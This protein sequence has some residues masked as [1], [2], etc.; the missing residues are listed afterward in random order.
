MHF[1]R[2]F[3][4]LGLLILFIVCNWF[5]SPAIAQYD[6]NYTIENKTDQISPFKISIA[7]FNFEQFF[8]PLTSGISF[9]GHIK[10]K[11]FYDIQ[12]RMGFMRNFM[13]TEG[14]MATSQEESFGRLAEAGFYLVIRDKIKKGKLKIVYSS[15]YGA[16]NYFNAACDYRKMWGLTF[17]AMLYNRATYISRD[18]SEYVISGTNHIMAPDEKFIHFNQTTQAFYAGIVRR[19]LK[20]AVINSHGKN[21]KR[22]LSN[23]FYLHGLFGN[24]VADDIIFNNISY[25]IDNA[26][27][28]PMGYRIGWQWD[29]KRTEVC[30]EFGK[31]PGVYLKTPYEKK[32]PDLYIKD[33]PYLNY[34][35][36][37]VSFNIINGD[38]WLAKREKQKVVEKK[39]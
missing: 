1:R 11:V 27:Q 32:D 3:V 33:N 8:V 23:K 4:S 9:E 12:Y 13:V 20:K 14:E 25:K 35:R 38:R 29:Q 19:K 34:A 17:G 39:E 30:F 21:Y 22:Y 26:T 31:M 18:S 15:S 7:P 36:L 5:I 10:N 37:V 2:T 24:T 28:I 16:D 6:Q